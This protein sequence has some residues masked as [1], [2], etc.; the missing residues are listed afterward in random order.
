MP[1]NFYLATSFIF[2]RSLRLRLF[3]LCFV[4]THVPLLAYCAWGLATGRIALA[5]FL[6]LILATVAGMVLALAGIGA[7]L[8]PIQVL[9]ET[10]HRDQG[11][12]PAL[13]DVGDV[14]HTLYAGVH[15]AAAATRSQLQDLSIAAHEDPLT[16]I[17]NRRGFMAQ[18]QAM[19]EAQRHGCLAILDIDFFKSVN[20]HLGHDEGD[21][22]L[23]AF[24]GRLSAQV[25][26]VDLV[27]RWGGE[28]FAVFFANCIEDEACWAL[29]RIAGR[30]RDDPVGAVEG[31]IITFSGGI[32]TWQGGDLD[33][34]LH[35]ADAALYIA[36]QTGRDR[37]CRAAPTPLKA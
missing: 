14:I 33:S 32:C 9:A 12:E 4:A 17:A 11:P 37:I 10:L 19:P 35:H 6:V 20:D 30:M 8:R 18:L 34:A 25:R 2:P 26:R 23:C 27:A 24:A 7:L 5:A 22:V 3:A 28:E 1:V 21:R 15:R 36:K 29:E 31:R 13:P 16:G